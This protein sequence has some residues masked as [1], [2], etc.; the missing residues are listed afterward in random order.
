M[1]N[2]EKVDMVPVTRADLKLTFNNKGLK[3]LFPGTIVTKKKLEIGQLDPKFL[4]ASIKSS[5]L[6]YTYTNFT[7]EDIELEGEYNKWDVMLKLR[8]F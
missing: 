7:L 3:M 1:K 8:L 2:E 6:R 5:E 4:A